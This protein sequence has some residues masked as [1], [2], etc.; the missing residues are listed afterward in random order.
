[1][2]QEFQLK[3]SPPNFNLPEAAVSDDSEP[4]PLS[5]GS[6]PAVRSARRGDIVEGWNSN[7]P[8]ETRK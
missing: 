7:A 2:E 3:P 6:K 4:F 8:A 1:M 5:K